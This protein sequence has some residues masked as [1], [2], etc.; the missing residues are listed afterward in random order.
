MCA[1]ARRSARPR[2][3]V[4]RVLAVPEFD[5]AIEG[6]RH[7]VELGRPRFG[8]PGHPTL[9]VT[10]RLTRVSLRQV[11]GRFAA[12]RAEL[13]MDPALSLRCLRH[14]YVTT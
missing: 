6:L 8:V 4:A 13:G 12:V 14:P 5:W 7:W 1:T 3:A 2:P 10:E 11:D 9:W